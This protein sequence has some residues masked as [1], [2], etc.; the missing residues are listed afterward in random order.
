M[1]WIFIFIILLIIELLLFI[2]LPSGTLRKIILLLIAAI[3]GALGFSI[4]DS[5]KDFKI[6]KKALK[7]Y[8]ET[9]D[10]FNSFFNGS[11]SL[12]IEP[13]KSIEENISEPEVLEDSLRKN[14]SDVSGEIRRGL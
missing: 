10:L 2:Y 14:L 3:I 6:R 5:I 11:I 8:R 1:I 13:P 7:R 12:N 9:C 4:K